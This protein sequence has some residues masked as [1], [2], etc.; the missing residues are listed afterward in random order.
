M[1]LFVY[2]K[3]YLKIYYIQLFNIFNLIN[4]LTFGIKYFTLNSEKL[5]KAT[6]TG[7]L[8]RS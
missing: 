2:L 4:D 3:S 8:P 1:L 5:S 7:D 6:D